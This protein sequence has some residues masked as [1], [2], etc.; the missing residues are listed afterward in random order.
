[1]DKSESFE[2]SEVR[3][4]IHLCSL[5]LCHRLISLALISLAPPATVCGVA[6]TFKG[7]QKG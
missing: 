6:P 4:E 1:M 3:M 7:G 5:E 2:R